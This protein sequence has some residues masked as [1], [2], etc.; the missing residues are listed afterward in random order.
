MVV[1]INT[2]LNDRQEDLPS[3]V[4]GMTPADSPA[5]FRENVQ[6]IIDRVRG[7]WQ[8]AGWPAEELHFLLTVSHPIGN[9]LEP[10]DPELLAFREE[11]KALAFVNPRTAS[12]RLDRLTTPAEMLAG[13]WYRSALDP[14]HLSPAGYAELSRRELGALLVAS[15]PPVCPTDING[16]D[17]VDDLDIVLFFAL[18]EAGEMDF[19]GDD[20]VDD[21]D[22]VLFFDMFEMGC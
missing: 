9:D 21:L 13:G 7:V 18:F 3:L 10:D 17:G 2:G 6:A 11:A 14:N 12:V 1:R 19:N 16:D 8:S 5:A 20:G 15:Q 4:T 22:I